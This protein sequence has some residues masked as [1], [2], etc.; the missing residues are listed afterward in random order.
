MRNKCKP[1]QPQLVSGRRVAGQEV[2]RV[3]IEYVRSAKVRG[4]YDP[5]T[6]TLTLYRVK[7]DE[8]RI[9]LMI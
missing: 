8:S 5:V 3:V 9:L 6:K 2:E 7:D 1:R 4:T